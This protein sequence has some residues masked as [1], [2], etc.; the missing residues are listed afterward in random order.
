MKRINLTLAIL[1]LLV[2]VGIAQVD[3]D[4]SKL[5]TYFDT[6]DKN[7]QFMGSVSV[8]KNGEVIYSKTIGFADVENKIKATEN[9]KYK[10]GSI[11]KT[12]TAALTLKGVEENKLKLE[13]TIDKWFPSIKNADKITLK[14][15]L[16]HR[17]G[18]HNFTDDQDYLTW[19]TQ[20]KTPE[21]MVELIAKAG[22]DFEP[23]IKASYSNSN[24]VLL[25]LILEKAFKKS[26][27]ELLKKYITTPLG[28]KNTYVFGKIDPNKNEC[29]SY[30]FAGTWQLEPETDSSIPLGAG[31][32][33]S[34]PK[35]LNVFA[36]ALFNGKLLTTESLDIM[37]HIKDG[38]GAG[39]FQMPF[40][41]KVSYGHSGGIDGFSSS[42]CHFADGNLSYALI[43]NAT[44]M[45]NN[46]I[47]I[48]VLSAI[49]GRPYEIP[50]FSNYSPKPEEL[51]QYLGVYASKQIPLKIT[52]TKNGNSLIG[53]GTG[54]QPLALEATEKDKFKF[55]QVG[56]K[57]EFFPLEG[58]MI[59]RQ[60]GAEITFNKEEK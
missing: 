41:N 56:A 33:I 18:L 26:Y 3:F 42:F 46:N 2:K 47:S 52:F 30:K 49:Y 35:D 25:T 27:P 32:I 54:Q 24:Y 15:L 17:S 43:S 5:D 40:A 37:K 28:L 50:V 19:N 29:K 60:N 7:N 8:S 45:N 11:S 10:I 51:D 23:D 9:H 12:L 48:A 38:Y 34:T 13:Q 6:I 31:A 39:L 20:A 14:H 36:D 22:S 21:Q 58:K 44:K 4:K 53:Q 55:D 59:L 1:L 57:F 16:T